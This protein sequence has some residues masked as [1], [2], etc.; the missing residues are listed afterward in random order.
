MSSEQEILN[1]AYRHLNN[2]KPA[3]AAPLFS[4]L[5][6]RDPDN[7]AVLGG[8]GLVALISDQPE[9]AVAL[10]SRAAKLSPDDASLHNNLGEAHRR[11]GDVQAASTAFDAA[12]RLNPRSP[13]SHHNQALICLQLTDQAGALHHFQAAAR[14]GTDDPDVY[15]GIGRLLDDKGDIDG[16]ASAMRTALFYRPDSAHDHSLLGIILLAHGRFAEGWPELEWRYLQDVDLKR[17]A[18]KQARHAPPWRGEPID[19]KTILAWGEQ[20]IGDEILFACMIPDLI[21][22]GAAVVVESET[23]LMPLFARSFTDADCVQRSDQ[24]M[25]EIAERDFDFQISTAGLG[26]YFRSNANDFPNRRQYLRA[27]PALTET[28]RLRYGPAPDERLVGVAWSS[29]NPATGADKSLRL[30]DLAEIARTPGVRLVN[31]QYG[32]TE[33]ER[34]AFECA[35][36]VSLIDDPDIDSLADLD[37]F[38]A[39]VAAMDLVISISNLTVPLAGALGV[40]TWVMAPV[41]M[42]WRWMRDRP[43]SPWY[44]S[45][46]LFRRA[47]GDDWSPVLTAIQTALPEFIAGHNEKSGPS[48][49]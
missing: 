15:L 36:G 49:A 10:L 37:G 24:D 46:R 20:G 47:I 23:R 1:Q 26:R 4:Q 12:I 39:Q 6:Q 41:K 13:E 16:A 30:D 17:H 19:G 48:N 38:A 45:V 31:L 40:P 9:A 21:A 42:D 11:A 25:P 8:F 43:D 2:G 35:H 14:L 34:T 3:K 29:A 22:A 33:R 32:D 27:D 44:P 5:M 28:L 7:P 18:E